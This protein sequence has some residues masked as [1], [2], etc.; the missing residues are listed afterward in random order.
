M[1]TLTETEAQ[2]KREAQ[3]PAAA[4]PGMQQGASNF[5]CPVPCFLLER[6]IRILQLMD[7]WKNFVNSRVC[8]SWQRWQYVQR[9][10]YLIGSIFRL[11]SSGFRNRVRQHP[12]RIE[13]SSPLVVLSKEISMMRS[14]II[15]VLFC[16]MRS[17]FGHSPL[18]NVCPWF[19]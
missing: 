10:A 2:D 4:R 7:I 11:F 3:D 9:K 13:R 1:N 16:M 6:S 18:F 19:I 8:P 5:I 12:W 17:C 14:C 15:V